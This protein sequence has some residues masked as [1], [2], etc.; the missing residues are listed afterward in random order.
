[1]PKLFNIYFKG[2]EDIEKNYEGTTDNFKLWLQK[3][4]EEREDKELEDDFEVEEVCLALFSPQVSE[5]N[6]A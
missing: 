2:C 4:N 3:H 6:D 5:E 1:M